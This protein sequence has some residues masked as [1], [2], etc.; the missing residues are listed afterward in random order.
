MEHQATARI[1]STFLGRHPE[2]RHQCSK[3]TK[4][5]DTCI[6][7]HVNVNSKHYAMKVYEEVEV[8]LLHPCRWPREN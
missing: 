6:G 2:T 5:D 4:W 7:I 3:S 8:E 1:F